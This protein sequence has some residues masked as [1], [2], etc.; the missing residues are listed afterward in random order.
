M[1][2]RST[3]RVRAMDRTALCDKDTGAHRPGHFVDCTGPE[4]ATAT[5]LV[6]DN[7]EGIERNAGRGV[8]GTVT[9][10]LA[11]AV[12]RAMRPRLGR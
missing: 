6:G 2:V 8:L 10:G 9:Y 4:T 11:A 1:A 5:V 12:P 3:R 7:R